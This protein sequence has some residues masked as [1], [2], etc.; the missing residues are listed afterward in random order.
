MTAERKTPPI[1]VFT[2]CDAVPPR[3]AWSC[4]I[5]RLAHNYRVV[6]FDR[7][8]FGYSDL[9]RTRIWTPTTQASLFAK[10]LDRLGVRNPVGSATPRERWW[11]SLA[12]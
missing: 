4:F 7:P 11:Q 10:A 2:Y 6:C 1:G 5:D 12:L 8:G 9:P 3:L